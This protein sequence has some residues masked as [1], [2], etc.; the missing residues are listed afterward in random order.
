MKRDASAT[1]LGLAALAAGVFLWRGESVRAQGAPGEGT[2]R[3]ITTSGTATVSTTPD[4]ARIFFGVRTT[5]PTVQAARDQNEARL[6]KFR[7]ALAA[8]KLPGLKTK[9]S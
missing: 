8:L 2:P 7:S 4:S 5:A 9:S 6:R 3:S 1:L